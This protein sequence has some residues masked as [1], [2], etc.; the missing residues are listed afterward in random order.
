MNRR[1]ITATGESNNMRRRPAAAQ[2]KE[3]SER[4]NSEASSQYIISKINTW[5]ILL[6]VLTALLSALTSFTL[7]FFGYHFE[8]FG[9]KKHILT[10]VAFVMGTIVIVFSYAKFAEEHRSSVNYF[11]EF[12]SKYDW[13]LN[14]LRNS[15]GASIVTFATFVAFGL[16]LN[17]N[18]D[19]FW[20]FRNYCGGY[21]II[22]ATF[23]CMLIVAIVPRIR[24]AKIVIGVKENKIGPNA[25][26]KHI[27]KSNNPSKEKVKNQIESAT[28][29]RSKPSET[30]PSVPHVIS[31]QSSDTESAPPPHTMRRRNSSSVQNT[32]AVRNAEIEQPAVQTSPSSETLT[33]K[34]SS[35]PLKKSD[36]PTSADTNSKKMRRRGG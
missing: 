20:F 3:I 22:I 5:C 32:T 17:K 28:R 16:L 8:D 18:H 19:Y 14:G 11:V 9:V 13:L 12:D 10:L 15:I 2:T 36:A 26:K 4:N 35:E 23:I 29:Q 31:E 24:L 1:N 27:K 30:P 21:I 34:P 33:S 25:P 6:F 7:W